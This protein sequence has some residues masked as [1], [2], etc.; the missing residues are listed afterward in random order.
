MSRTKAI[1]W[2]FWHHYREK[3]QRERA[4]AVVKYGAYKLFTMVPPGPDNWW[5]KWVLG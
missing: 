1:E 4:D 5:L 2:L 3:W